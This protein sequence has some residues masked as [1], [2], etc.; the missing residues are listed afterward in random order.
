MQISKAFIAV[1]IGLLAASGMAAYAYGGVA[2]AN[3][4]VPCES[5][6]SSASPSVTASHAGSITQSGG[7]NINLPNRSKTPPTVPTSKAVSQMPHGGPSQ[8]PCATSSAATA[9]PSSS[10]SKSPSPTPLSPLPI[11]GSDLPVPALAG[12]GLALVALGIVLL[13]VRRHRN[14]GSQ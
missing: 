8:S 14:A 6:T 4:P 1:S 9:S 3:V 12:L 13:G 2:S 10:F 7:V 5:A 11:T